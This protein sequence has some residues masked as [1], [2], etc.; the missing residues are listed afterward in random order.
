M[1]SFSIVAPLD[2]HPACEFIGAV[3]G[4]VVGAV[5]GQSR[6]SRGA[7]APA[8]PRAPAP[9]AAGAPPRHCCSGQPRPALPRPHRRTL[10]SL[11]AASAARIMEEGL[12]DS[13]KQ[14]SRC[15]SVKRCVASLGRDDRLDVAVHLLQAALHGALRQMSGNGP[16]TG[17]VFLGAQRLASRARQGPPL[18]L[19]PEGEVKGH[20]R[21]RARRQFP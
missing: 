15:N 17:G 1:L 4:A 5:E 18:D 7:V 10:A 20:P 6:G 8:A 3:V 19:L 13:A 14:A 16:E 9:P 11:A 12:T 2:L 21:G